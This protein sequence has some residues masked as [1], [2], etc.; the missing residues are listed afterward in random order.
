MN[1]AGHNGS[2]WRLQAVALSRMGEVAKEIALGALASDQARIA[3]HVSKLD[4]MDCEELP[5]FL[6]FIEQFAPDSLPKLFETVDLNT[7]SANWQTPLKNYRKQ[8]REG[9]RQ[10]FRFAGRHAA[11]E[12]K[13]LADRLSAS[14][15]RRVRQT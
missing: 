9:A 2:D 3:E 4:M 10:I 13:A 5:F 1:L 11:G 7:A 15:P 14:R 12:L 6:E 8:V